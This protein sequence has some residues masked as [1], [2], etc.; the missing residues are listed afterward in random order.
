[1]AVQAHISSPRDGDGITQLM[2]RAFGPELNTVAIHPGFQQWKYWDEH[3]FAV[4]GRSYVLNGKERTVGHACRWP[5]RILTTAGAF[6]TFHLIDWAAD[7]THAGAGL[8]VLRDSCDNSAALFSIGGTAMTRRMLPAFGEHLRRRTS[9]ALSYQVAGKFYFLNRP[10]KPVAPAL[11]DSPFDWRMPARAA[12]NALRSA[13]PIPRLPSGYSFA[14]VAVTEIPEELWPRPTSNV[15]TS[16][17]TPELLQHFAGCPVLQRP[18]FFVVSH[19][20][21]P[22]AYFFLVLAGTQV[23][24]ADYGPAGLD[25]SIA[26]VI[27][28]AAQLAAKQHYPDALRIAAATSEPTVRSGFIDSGFRDSY[29]DEIRGLMIDPELSRIQQYRLT[30]LDGDALCLL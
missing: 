25:S 30:Y 13:L 21:G 1:M 7:S 23:R 18:M 5:I 15:A 12:R 28:A 6:D 29:E 17:R 26:K 4:M 22:V 2:Q 27:G 16:A 10:L 14:E 24:L 19:G 9:R 8:Q 11:N 20:S 3:P